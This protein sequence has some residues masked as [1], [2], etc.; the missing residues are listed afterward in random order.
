MLFSLIVSV[1]NT[2][3]YLDQCLDS[4]ALQD[5]G[6]YELIIVD[7]G[8]TD[9]S[10]QIC[11]D[12]CKG[13]TNAKVIHQENQGLAGARNTGIKEAKGEWIWFIDSDD[14]IVPGALSALKERMRFAKG[15]LYAFQFF[16]T[17]ENGENHE[18][19]F[20]REFQEK[21]RLDEERFYLWNM[22]HR[23]FPYKDGWEA[24]TRLYKRSIII[25][26]G[27]AFKDTTKVF[28][29]DL[30]FTAEYMMC[31]RTEVMLVNYLYY[32]RY[33]GDSIT[34]TLDQKTVLPRLINLL[35]ENYKEAVRFKKKQ[36]IKNFDTFCYGIIRTH[37]HKLDKLTDDEIRSE[38]VNATKNKHIGKYM[39]KVRT[40][41]FKEIEI[42]N[43]GS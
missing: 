28:A 13:R 19:I 40:R 30:C 32:Y 4:I 35:E 23:L 37:I 41:L 2:K 15:D 21:F 8:S 39:K 3:K 24:P 7:D 9:G 29:E 25:D 18:S 20:F 42:R 34:N 10:A 6:D 38:I 22:D 27:L 12:F 31:C 1:Y 16:R 17:D 33:R 5:F 43:L 14:F 11:D 26:N 36:T